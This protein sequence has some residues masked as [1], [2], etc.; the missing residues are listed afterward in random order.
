MFEDPTSAVLMVLLSLALGL[1]AVIAVTMFLKG[2]YRHRKSV[3]VN[4]SDIQQEAVIT[5]FNKA[6]SVLDA[7][8]AEL[9]LNSLIR[10]REAGVLSKEEFNKMFLKVRKTL[11]YSPAFLKKQLKNDL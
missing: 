6:G 3:A 5:E 1:L 11:T 10:Q 7:R 8:K 4:A 9:E 2:L